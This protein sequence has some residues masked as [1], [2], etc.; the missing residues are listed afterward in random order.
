[1]KAESTLRLPAVDAMYQPVIIPVDRSLIPTPPPTKRQSRCR[2]H[3]QLLS[4]L[5][6]ADVKSGEKVLLVLSFMGP[7][8][9]RIL[10]ELVAKDGWRFS[11]V[12]VDLNP[13]YDPSIE[14]NFNDIDEARWF[15][16]LKRHWTSEDGSL[17][18]VLVVAHPVCKPWSNCG[19]PHYFTKIAANDNSK[20]RGKRK[21]FRRKKNLAPHLAK[22]LDM[23]QLMVHKLAKFITEGLPHTLFHVCVENPIGK[24]GEQLAREMG[25]VRDALADYQDPNAYVYYC[26]YEARGDQLGGTCKHG[27]KFPYPK[28]TNILTN[29]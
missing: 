26:Q 22:R 13:K 28:Q 14:M 5:L 16:V 29:Y 10:K 2:V 8:N 20:P 12:T 3:N 27:E 17:R 24:L 4:H 1:M 6:H 18:P 15:D 9:R 19:S 11:V 21:D 23:C 7:R 25:P